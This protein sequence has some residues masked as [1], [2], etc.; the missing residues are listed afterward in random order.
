MNAVFRL[1][2]VT[3]KQV[4]EVKDTLDEKKINYD[5]FK[6]A[7]EAWAYDEA[8]TILNDNGFQNPNI[9]FKDKESMDDFVN[10]NKKDLAERIMNDDGVI[11]DV[12][13]LEH[14]DMLLREKG[15]IE[16]HEVVDQLKN[17]A[18]N[19]CVSSITSA[20]GAISDEF[21]K[22]LHGIGAEVNA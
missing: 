8:E 6:S 7:Y 15:Y 16:K 19:V 3:E 12:I 14:F 17:S 10:N 13:E 18:R 20:I 11:D 5:A 2:D 22:L 21:D 1:N 9:K 4:K